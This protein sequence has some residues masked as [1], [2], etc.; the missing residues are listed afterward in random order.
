MARFAH[1]ASW[2]VWPVVM[3]VSLLAAALGLAAGFS[4]G[5]WA[6]AVSTGNFVLVLLLERV[7]PRSAQTD[8]FRDR[9]VWND[10]GHGILVASLARPL[11][12][13][14][15]AGLAGTL[16]AAGV[17]A[18]GRGL[19]PGHWPFAAQVAFGLALW[20]FGGYWTHR[21]LHRMPLWRF[22]SL[23]HDGNP[24]HV[25]KGNRIHVGEDL[26]QYPVLLVP[27]LLLGLPAEVFLWMTLWNNF[28]GALAHSN[29]EQRFPFFAHYLLPT[30]ANH[31]VH[32]AAPRH[33]H[34]SNYAGVTPIW[35]VLFGTYRHPELHR[36][37]ALG[38]EDSPV[39]RGF[40]AQVAFPFRTR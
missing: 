18:E 32:H 40:L 12:G 31:V 21:A 24:L 10:V 38:I 9:Q 17:L 8:L 20:S 35:D 3:A 2:G 11:G 16:A 7:L 6:F 27:L 4:P 14:L 19:W 15:A 39:P 13:A 22:H 5:V 30:P 28:E 37:T 1:V 26:F 34:D 25:L 29:V 36:V 33:L 23:H